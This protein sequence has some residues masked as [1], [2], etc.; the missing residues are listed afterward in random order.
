[1]K[2]YYVVT[3]GRTTGLFYSWEDCKEQVLGYNNALYKSFT[4]KKDA[5]NF[6][7]NT[8]SDKLEDFNIDNMIKSLKENEMIAFID[9]SYSNKYRLYSYGII[10]FTKNDEIKLKKAYNNDEFIDMRNVAGEVKS[11]I[12]TFKYARDNDIKVLNIFYD[13]SGIE[14]WANGSW[15]TNNNLTKSYRKIY[16]EY[17]K[18]MEIRFYKVKSHSNIKY[19][20][21]ADSLAKK[22]IDEYIKD[23]F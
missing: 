8:D 1:M 16:L 10:I 14:N 17:S 13:Y 11:A 23:N 19:N 4:N 12:A 21:V 9:G 6:L 15:K 18:S 3:R 7:K 22:A 5:L 2:K 20:D